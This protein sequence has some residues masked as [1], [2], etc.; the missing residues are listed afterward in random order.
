MPNRDAI[1][2]MEIMGGMPYVSSSKRNRS[3]KYSNS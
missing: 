1:M 2:Q 3:R